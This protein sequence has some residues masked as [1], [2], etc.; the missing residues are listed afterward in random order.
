VGASHARIEFTYPERH[1]RI[2]PFECRL[3]AGEP[4]PRG[5]AELRWVTPEELSQ[6][7]FPP[8]NAGLLEKIRRD[9]SPENR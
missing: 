9:R 1:V 3:L 4:E 8:A 7:E 6:Y 2:H 5:C